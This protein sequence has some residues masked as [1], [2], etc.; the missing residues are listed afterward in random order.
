MSFDV[1]MVKQTVVHPHRGIRH[2]SKKERATDT[3]N[4][5]DEWPG[6][7]LKGKS[8]SPKMT[9]CITPFTEFQNGKRLEME[10]RSVAVRGEGEGVGRDRRM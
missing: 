10:N 7:I 9:Y 4:E 1:F 5:Q 8:Q 2:S 3:R 6:I